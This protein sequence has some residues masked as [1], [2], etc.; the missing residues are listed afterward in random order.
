MNA[1]GRLK[2]IYVVD[3]TEHTLRHAESLPAEEEACHFH[4]EISLVCS[5]R[6]PAMVVQRNLRDA[7]D[8]VLPPLVP[9]LRSASRRFKV[10][11]AAN[12]ES[13]I[14]AALE[15]VV[16]HDSV[17]KIEGITVRVTLED[18]ARTFLRERKDAERSVSRSEWALKAKQ[19]EAMAEAQ[20]RLQQE[21]VDAE[22]AARRQ[23]RD[24]VRLKYERQLEHERLEAEVRRV[25]LEAAV[26]AL[27]E[28]PLWNEE[29]LR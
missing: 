21:Q 23:D 9:A 15:D 27:Q 24:A 5:V 16:P 13:S 17:F 22:E 19:R 18:D 7:A 3:L 4:A 14:R 28:T 29:R 25:E 6:D 8:A 1:A 11:D 20:L 12:A 26:T 10:E 2:N